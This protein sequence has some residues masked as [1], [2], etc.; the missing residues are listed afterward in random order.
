MTKSFHFVPLNIS[1]VIRMPGSSPCERVVQTHTP[2]QS[3]TSAA[4]EPL[5]VTCQHFTW[6]DPQQRHHLL[7]SVPECLIFHSPLP[8]YFISTFLILPFICVVYICLY[9]TNMDF[10]IIVLDPRNTML[11]IH[12][13][14]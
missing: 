3:H 9:Y 11:R 13:S 2:S 5:S 14:S 12:D 6:Q 10:P 1:S 8:N 7:E 4:S